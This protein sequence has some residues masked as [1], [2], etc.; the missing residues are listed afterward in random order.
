M[1]KNMKEIELLYRCGY[2]SNIE[3]DSIHSDSDEIIR[4]LTSIIKTMKKKLTNN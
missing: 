4:L 2:I 1:K 3:F